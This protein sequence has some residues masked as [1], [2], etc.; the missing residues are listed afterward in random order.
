M[1]QMEKFTIS[2]T[3]IYTVPHAMLDAKDTEI[4]KSGVCTAHLE[5]TIQYSK[6]KR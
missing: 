3:R 6:R 1:H 4:S 5:L 2:I